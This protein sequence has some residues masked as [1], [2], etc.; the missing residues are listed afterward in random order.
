MLAAKTVDVKPWWLY[1]D[2]RRFTPND[3]VAPDWSTRFPGF[4]LAPALLLEPDGKT[5]TTV[6]HICREEA[7][8][9]ETGSVY[10]SG[11]PAPKKGA[12][13]PNGRLTQPPG[14]SGFARNAKGRAVSCSAGVGF[15]SSVECGCGVGLERCMPSPGFQNEQPAFVMPTHVP[16]GPGLPFEASPQPPAQWLR[17]WW[18]EEAK[19]Y[20]DCVF[21]EDRDVR[22]L[23][24]GRSDQVNGP[25]AQ[26][27]R[28]MA[29][30]TCCGASVDLGYTE[31]E[32]LVEPGAVPEAL[33]PQDTA[34]WLPIAH[35]GPHAAGLLTMPVFLTKY[36]SRR[37]RAHVVASAFLCHEFVA[38][39]VRLAPSTEPDLTKRPGCNACH[40]TLE[41]MAA[42]F[43]RVAESD[44][45]WLP[46]TQ[47]PMTLPKCASEKAPG[48][49]KGYYD[50]AFAGQLRGAYA[51][52]SRAEAGPAGLAAEVA[53]SP[54]FAP[55]VVSTVA[56]GLLGRALTADDAAWKA[57]LVSA[58]TEGGYRMRALVRAIVTSPRY[59]DG[60]DAR[61]P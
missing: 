46:A 36:G 37:A 43:T 40:Q 5:P 41:P 35:R 42:A 49:C 23:L 13:P 27:Y 3:W 26:F 1:A 59:R 21:L 29:S 15:A 10:A 6:I 58:F 48:S 33:V 55:C 12:P 57:R 45:T 22:E 47:L 50:P 4:Q 53:A 9:A 16:F 2:A 7:Q 51:A 25:L 44:W 32:P 11:R 60:N 19:R 34:T 56:S 38:D 54:D 30:A 17:M 28:T 39:T 61:T 24:I 52:P 31:P 18:G 8:T 20:M 14:D